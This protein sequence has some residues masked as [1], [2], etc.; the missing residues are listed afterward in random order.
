MSS[1][2]DEFSLRALGVVV[3]VDIAVVVVVV[4]AV[5]IPTDSNTADSSTWRMAPGRNRSF[6]AVPSLTPSA[7][8][9]SIAPE[10]TPPE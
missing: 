1:S 6:F 5:A 10:Q 3:V 8:N 2:I 4:V 9:E 7:T